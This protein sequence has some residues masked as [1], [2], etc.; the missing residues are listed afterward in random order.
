MKS[1]LKMLIFTVDD[2][3]NPSEGVLLM[4]DGH[5]KSRCVRWAHS[6]FGQ[7]FKPKSRRIGH[8]LRVYH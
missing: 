1:K 2:H 5:E 8:R 7:V 4:S 6:G 3:Q